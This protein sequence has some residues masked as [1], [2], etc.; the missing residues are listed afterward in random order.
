MHPGGLKGRKV[1]P[2]IVYHHANVA[3]LARCFVRLHKMY[4]SLCPPDS[5]AG[6]FY[7]TP[8]KNLEAGC[9]YSKVPV[10]KNKLAMAVSSMC[11]KCGIEGYKTNHFL[12]ATA[13]TRLYA[14]GIDQG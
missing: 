6:A 3:N 7:L 13:A 5:P 12:R 14:S 4:I 9:W 8:L 10:G 2:K 1:K 11:K